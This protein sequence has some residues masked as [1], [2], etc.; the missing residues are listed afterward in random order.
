MN[1]SAHQTMYEPDRTAAIILGASSWP[2]MP[3]FNAATA[4][5]NTANGLREYLTDSTGMRLPP[6]NLLDLF[7]STLSSVQ[8]IDAV[9]TFLRGRMGRVH[10]KHGE[11]MLVLVAYIGHGA[12]FE[13]ERFYCLLVRDT[14]EP[15][16][17]ESSLRVSTLAGTLKK[18]APRSARVVILDSCFAAEA[19]KGFQSDVEQVASAKVQK[20]ADQEIELDRLHQP[21]GEAA[22]NASAQERPDS[23]GVAL[24]CASSS[25][26]PAKLASKDSFTLFGRALLRAL[27]HGDVHKDRPLSLRDIYDLVRTHLKP[28]GDAPQPQIHTPEQ[29]GDDLAHRRIFPNPGT[30]HLP[31]DN[32]SEPRRR[33][34][35]TI[36]AA[37]LAVASVVVAGAVYFTVEQMQRWAHCGTEIPTLEQI[38]GEC[39]GFTDGEVDLFQPSGGDPLVRARIR[40]VLSTL[41]D[42]NRLAEQKHREQPHRP[43]VTLISLEAL[44]AAEGGTVAGLTAERES[45]QGFAVAQRGQL[46][47]TDPDAPLVRILVGNTGRGTRHGVHVAQMVREAAERDRSVVGV[48]GFN[49]S[50]QA[51]LDTIRTLDKEKIPTVATT[52]SLDELGDRIVN[53]VQV[54]PQNRN[55][56]ATAAA[57]AAQLPGALPGKARVYYSDDASDLYS[58]NLRDDA[59][60]WFE[61]LGFEVETY[62][63]SP[64]E[65]GSDTEMYQP[66]D[67][68]TGDAVEA[69][70]SVCSSSGIVFFAGRGIPDYGDFLRGAAP[71]A[72][73]VTIIGGDDV[74]K[75]VADPATRQAVPGVPYYYMS[76]APAP[77]TDDATSHEFYGRLSAMFPFEQDLAK[78]DRSLDGHAA[79]SYDAARLYIT[80]VE[81]VHRRSPGEVGIAAVTAQLGAVGTVQGVTGTFFFDPRSRQKVPQRKPVTVLR[82]VGG[83][84]EGRIQAYCGLFE[85]RPDLPAPWCPPDA[86]KLPESK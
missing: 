66:G 26:D 23:G 48:V 65:R 29:N 79:L 1:S 6:E 58:T 19:V 52:L 78:K 80:A 16:L 35:R 49:M 86:D 5:R 40:Q 24:L 62:L 82:V 4:F 57:F 12:F 18:T 37:M 75:H 36:L 10:S 56:A 9:Q 69:G 54:A 22:E 76:F 42:Q 67:T 74:T 60:F 33:R 68:V 77:V 17:V 63:Y 28:I 3:G 20:V 31:P 13:T 51:T 53:F 61:R 7:D 45:L 14:H 64:A 34:Q 59:E 50:N 47:S 70:A 71:C 84:V 85:G 25:R 73:D 38:D 30:G 55:E 27:R 81:Q 83:E 46:D 41:R 11:K 8:Q 39:V 2:R 43:Y 32:E 72:K 44:T 21:V 15:S